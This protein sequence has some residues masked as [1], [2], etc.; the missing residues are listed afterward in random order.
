VLA[1]QELKLGPEHFEVA[2][3]W[4]NLARAYF[5]EGRYGEAESLYLRALALQEKTLGSAHPDEAATLFNY[6]ELL[7]KTHRNREAQKLVRRAKQIDAQAGRD[8]SMQYTVGSK[9]LRR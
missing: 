7:R 6:A 1:I 9:D 2:R 3:T 4:N 5:A 8:K